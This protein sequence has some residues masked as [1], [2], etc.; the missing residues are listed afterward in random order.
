M[1]RIQRLT[2]IQV[3]MT[4]VMVSMYVCVVA[5]VWWSQVDHVTR[6]VY[7]RSIVLMTDDPEAL[8]Q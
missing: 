2:D 4:C 1:S 5:R 3:H 6:V 8:R 7:V